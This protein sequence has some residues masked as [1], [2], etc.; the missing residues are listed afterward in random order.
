[1]VN[2]SIEV[3][4][5]KSYENLKICLRHTK[6]MRNISRLS[7]ISKSTLTLIAKGKGAYPGSLS[8]QLI[9]EEWAQSL[10]KNPEEWVVVKK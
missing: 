10:E 3:K 7:G 2:R 5:S 8:T 6:K 9:L 4:M 1:M